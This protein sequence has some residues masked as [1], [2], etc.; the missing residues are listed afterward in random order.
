MTSAQFTSH[1]T[2]VAVAAVTSLLVVWTTIVRDDGTGIGYFMILLAVGVG[3]F[4]AHFRSAGMARTMCGVSI[5]QV[6]LGIA[7]ATAPVTAA[8]ADGPIR[9]LAANAAFSVLWLVSAASFRRSA[10]QARN[11]SNALDEA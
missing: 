2:G 5:M 6:L 3:W 10:T 9:A 8:I 11:R 1:R 7:I 4:S